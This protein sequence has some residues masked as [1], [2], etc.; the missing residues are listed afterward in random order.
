[1]ENIASWIALIGWLLILGGGLA[2]FIVTFR[3]SVWWTL[4]LLLLPWL[5]FVPVIVYWPATKK[6]VLVWLGGLC[7]VITGAMFGGSAFGLF[8]R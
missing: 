4:F 6:G 1:M 7:S 5:A 3:R 2:L 8:Y